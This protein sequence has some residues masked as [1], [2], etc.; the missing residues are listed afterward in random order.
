VYTIENTFTIRTAA[1]YV[2]TR[3]NI[4]IQRAGQLGGREFAQT[5]RLV[6]QEVP[7]EPTPRTWVAFQR[8]VNGTHDDLFPLPEWHG[9]AQG[10]EVV[11]LDRSARPARAARVADRELPEPVAV[12]VKGAHF[13]LRLFDRLNG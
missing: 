12:P 11:H 1:K 7:T 8:I 4:L 13:T 9:V 2:C 5:D 6:A 3:V 10:G